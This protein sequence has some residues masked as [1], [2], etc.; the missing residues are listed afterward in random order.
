MHGSRTS[1]C[2]NRVMD[3]L[4]RMDVWHYTLPVAVFVEI[5]PILPSLSR[6]LGALLTLLN[7]DFNGGWWMWWAASEFGRARTELPL[8]YPDGAGSCARDSKS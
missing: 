4:R 3:R 2:F 6:G 8:A 7:G 1:L 5:S